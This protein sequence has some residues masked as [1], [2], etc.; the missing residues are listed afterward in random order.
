MS[1]ERAKEWRLTG[2]LGAGL[3]FAILWQSLRAEPA[4]ARAAP[5]SAATEVVNREATAPAY[6]RF[7][8]TEVVKREAAALAYERFAATEVVNRGAGTSAFDPFAVAL[9]A[10][11][12]KNLE[13]SI[14]PQCYTKTGA[15]SN[16]CYACHTASQAPNAMH[17]WDLQESYDFSEAG[18]TNAWT[19]LFVDRRAGIAGISDDEVLRYVREDNYG[20]LRAAV[21]GR[22][23]YVFDMQRG[24]DEEGFARDES[25]WRSY[26]FKPFVGA[27]W[28]T[29][30]S[31]GDAFIRLPAGLRRTRAEY[32]INLAVVEA[33]VAGDPAVP[34]A[35][36]R[37]PCD[38][39][40][41]AA[42]GLDLDGDGVLGVARI[43]KG[44]PARYVGSD[45]AVRRYV[46]PEGTEFLHSVRYLD[47]EA[48]GLFA[49]RMKELRYARKVEGLDRWAMQRAYEEEKEARQEGQ[50]PRYTGS[51]TAGLRGDFGW[52]LQG[53]IEDEAGRLRLQTAEEH[54]HCMGC[55]NGIGV[56]VD[57]T[58]S[59]P[60]KVPGARGW[61]YQTL[62]GM[63]DV[64]SAGGSEPEFLQ[65]MRR[66]GAG[67]ELR[68]NAEMLA[69]FFPG[70]ALDEAAV[71]RASQ[72]GDR[73][74]A[75]L[76]APSR[77]RA[78]ALNKA[79]WL[80]VREQ[81]FVR[82]RDAVLRPMEDV[83]A[84]IEGEATELAAAGTVYHDGRL[85]LAW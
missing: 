48:P 11:E 27:F 84:K 15:R 38:P 76:L 70:G 59:F 17:D 83:H 61:G 75:W 71:R 16:P 4:V 82:G 5:A 42:V 23:G 6:E 35:E 85:Q 58:F 7:A 14:P 50:T 10:T 78:L 29:N 53:F 49:A 22:V 20:P 40:D 13:A 67:D 69:R 77:E 73:D 19:N 51:P 34:T 9:A 30:G 37:W 63:R 3:L 52:Q 12:V 31:V 28:P 2:L 24:L 80:V 21:A 72:G 81:S 46:Y 25:G 44:L 45:E 60:R 36:L 57:Q 47:P 33:A 56:T 65:Y 32:R 26:I 41:E 68:A 62:V 18:R 43:I 1:D 54:R 66:V 74:L 64:A 55:H 39:L 79:Y 8:A